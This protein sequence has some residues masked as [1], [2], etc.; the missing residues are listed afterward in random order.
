MVEICYIIAKRYLILNLATNPHC[1]S[2]YVAL[3]TNVPIPVNS[4]QNEKNPSITESGP[5]QLAVWRE[6]VSPGWLGG[7]SGR[8]QGAL[9]ER[10]LKTKRETLAG[11][12]ILFVENIRYRM[13]SY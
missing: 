3:Y 6:R 13:Q 9:T 4:L 10:F 7:V 11:Q 2:K 5:L 1:T 8:V 12:H